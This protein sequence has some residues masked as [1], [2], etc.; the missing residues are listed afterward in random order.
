MTVM[1]PKALSEINNFTW[2]NTDMSSGSHASQENIDDANQLNG[3]IENSGNQEEITELKENEETSKLKSDSSGEEIPDN[4]EEHSSENENLKTEDAESYIN[5]IED[6]DTISNSDKG[7]AGVTKLEDLELQIKSALEQ[8]ENSPVIEFLQN[9][10]KQADIHTQSV[11]TA[12]EIARDFVAKTLD[13]AEAMKMILQYDQMM[14]NKLN[15]T[16]AHDFGVKPKTDEEARAIM[17]DRAQKMLNLGQSHYDVSHQISNTANPLRDYRFKACDDVNAI[18]DR[19]STVK[20]IETAKKEGPADKNIN[21]ID[22][23]QIERTKSENKEDPEGQQRSE[24]N[25]QSNKLSAES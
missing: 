5:G 8:L 25:N 12:K 3:R 10:S 20:D 22:E 2:C 18:Q 14:L 7:F 13:L 16:T 19:L 15:L 24:E 23:S 9:I 11:Q 17:I 4:T 1:R 21:E 6:S